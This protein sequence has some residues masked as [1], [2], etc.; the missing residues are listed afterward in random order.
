MSDIV[1]L[2][3][4]SFKGEKKEVCERNKVFIAVNS[5]LFLFLWV[6][7]ET[8]W[9]LFFCFVDAREKS[10]D[11]QPEV[12]VSG[13]QNSLISRHSLTVAVCLSRCEQQNEQKKNLF[14]D[15]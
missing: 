4:N 3:K 7:T 15:K 14:S 11:A 8:F 13:T 5:A 2:A 12:C 1:S 6:E 9:S 10:D